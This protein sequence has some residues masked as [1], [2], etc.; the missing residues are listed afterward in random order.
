V[1]GRS[2][3]LS[4]DALRGAVMI[5]M[6]L[7]H[8]RDFIHRGA[9][10]FSPEDLTQTTPLLFFTRWIT[11]LCAPTFVF[12]A[13]LGAF[14]RLQRTGSTGDLARFLWTRGVWL[15]L[16]EI[17]V[18]RLAMNF[19]L[20]AGYPVLLLIL[21]ALGISMIAL[22]AL[23]HL[24]RRVLLALS[25]GVIASHNLLDGM[26]AR[27]FGAFA[28]LWNVLH[29]SG[30]FSLA[31]AT[32]VVG[33]PVLPWIAVIALGFCAGDL[34]LLDAAR[35][36]RVL[37]GAGLASVA[38]FV[39]L[40]LVNVY[41]DPSP[42]SPQS[43]PTVTMLSFFR[44][45]KY[46]PS[47]EFLLMTLGPALLALAALDGRRLSAKNPLVAIGR[48]PFFYYVIHFWLLHLVAVVLAW[49]RYGGASLAF[50]FSPLPSMGG[51]RPLF[52]PDFGYSL[53]V[54]YIVWI[55]VVA[56]LYPMCLWF[57]RVKA[58]RDEWWIS[59]V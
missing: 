45:T 52:P 48:V 26:T 59:Y 27:Q 23:I 2:R 51:A 46:P 8:T 54:T 30:V 19:T 15:I 42:W 24:P 21:W 4:I 28:P 29:Q 25:V 12:L 17:T 1:A 38:L 22:A 49:L 32:I 18:M 58:R 34:F 13:G 7:D 6:A 56:A 55:G 31:G 40:R 44:T 10:T 47:L 9:M 50:L 39:I 20:E 5:I 3:L 35:R 41:G 37:A 36:R 14:F 57:S 33:Y 43:T 53:G 11:H 16:V